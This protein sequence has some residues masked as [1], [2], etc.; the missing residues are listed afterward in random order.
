M[1]QN[2]NKEVL[3]LHKLWLNS[4]PKGQRAS[5]TAADLRGAT[6]TNADLTNADLRNAIL[7]YADL[8]SAYLRNAILEGADLRYAILK[9]ADL[10]S[11]YLTG[12]DL[13]GASLSGATFDK[14]TKFPEGFD[15][16]AHG[17]ILVGEKAKP[18][19]VAQEAV[20]AGTAAT[21]ST[22][23][24]ELSAVL[25]KHGLTLGKNV[26]LNINFIG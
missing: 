17:M 4:D 11:A 20:A 2:E 10:R 5:L 26:T 14:E 21:S 23:H 12:A 25:A 3:R 24:E 6:L 13:F 15:P 22:L 19:S 7:K 1:N 18:S 8:R 9:Y 16:V